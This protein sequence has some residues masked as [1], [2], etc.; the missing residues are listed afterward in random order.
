MGDVLVVDDSVAMRMM[1][2]RTAKKAGLDGYNFRQ[3]V[4]GKDG[5]EAIMKKTP[6]LVL[7]DWNMPNMTGIELLEEIKRQQIK[8]KFGFVTTEGTSEMRLRARKAG[9]LFLLAKPFTVA[10][11]EHVLNQIMD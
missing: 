8:L 5:L 2:I 4:D 6:F 10:S 7:S 1:V 3:A 9:A 11:F